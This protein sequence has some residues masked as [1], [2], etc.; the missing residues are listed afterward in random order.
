MS[1]DHCLESLQTRF[2]DIDF[3]A[4]PLVPGR[5]G[6]RAQ[7]RV[8]VSPDR[9]LEVMRFLHDD[10]RTRFDLLADLTCV[11][12]LYFPQARDRYGVT[13]SLYSTTH[14]HRLF[15]KCFVNDPDPTVPSVTAIWRGADWPER[16]VY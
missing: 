10:P 11:D 3:A 1:V 9:L 13:Y 2:A 8:R 4:A 6:A 16:E 14:Q 15:V 12:Y 5:E 7:I